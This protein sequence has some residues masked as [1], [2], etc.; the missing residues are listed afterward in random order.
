MTTEAVEAKEIDTVDDID[1]EA[2]LPEGDTNS[3]QYLEQLKKE[4]AKWRLRAKENQ[5]YEKKFKESEAKLNEVASQAE[6]AMKQVV[7]IKTT[8]ERRMIDAELRALAT[9]FGLKKMDYLKL[10]DRSSVKIDENGDV[11]GAREM[12]E[13]LKNSEPELFK[14]PTTTN[15]NH[16]IRNSST[17]KVKEKKVLAL[18]AVDYEK[19]EQ[20]FLRGLRS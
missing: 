6:L 13:G 16:N 10:A 18:S 14:L 4:N 5:V 11:I 12:I 1:H 15:I 20:A 19:E 2:E 3:K 8:A 7:E 9:E 17:E